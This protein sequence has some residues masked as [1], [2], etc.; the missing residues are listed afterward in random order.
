[1]TGVTG[2]TA[3][4]AGTSGTGV[5]Q[6]A[7]VV[8]F[9]V[10]TRVV[11]WATTALA[12]VVLITGTI[13]YVDELSAKIGRRELLKNLH[14]TC[15]LL[16]AVPL[17]LGVVLPHRGRGLRADLVDLGH[18]TRKDRQWLRRA[19]RAIPAGKFNGGQK[20][21]AALFAG[22]FAVQL[23]TGSLMNWNE[24]FSDSWRTGAT[25]VHDWGYLA[26]MVL[27]V[28]HIGKATREPELMRSMIDGNVPSWWAERKRPGWVNQQHP[29]DD[30]P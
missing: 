22:L 18:W 17:L 7:S 27:V 6:A 26:G 12:T 28:G 19:T 8:R 14:V 25:F 16:L 23:L 30:I 24:P 13:L 1:V 10:V 15:G 3:G 9:D 4:T 21:A 29:P 2:G 5:T 11:H 20:L